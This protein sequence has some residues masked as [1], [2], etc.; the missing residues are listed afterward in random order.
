MQSFLPYYTAGAGTGERN[1]PRT[2]CCTGN[3]IACRTN[4]QSAVGYFSR[5]NNWIALGLSVEVLF[6]A[7][8]IYVPQLNR[9]FTASPFPTDY[10]GLILLAPFV[11]FGIEELRKFFVRKGAHFL[12]V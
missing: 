4:R 1:S 10:W 6:I 2:P 7:S 5:P 12:A 3:V 8:I 11:I 9:F